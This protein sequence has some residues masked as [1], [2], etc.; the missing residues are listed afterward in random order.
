[1]QLEEMRL[2]HCQNEP[3]GEAYSLIFCIL[4]V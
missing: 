4:T 1:M 2:I 3:L